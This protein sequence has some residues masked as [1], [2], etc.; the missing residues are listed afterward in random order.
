VRVFG[1]VNYR[2]RLPRLWR[3]PLGLAVAATAFLAPSALQASSRWETLEAIHRV[4]NPR[5]VTAPGRHGE[6]GA[7]QFRAST[8]R[9]HTSLPFAQAL[10]RAASE[11][12]AVRHYEWLRRGL[13]RNGLADNPYNIALA[14]NGGLSAAVQGRASSSAHEY[15]ERVNN[16]VA[17]LRANRL[18]SNP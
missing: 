12:V 11:R 9:M 16:I 7:Y 17:H 14:W 2:F 5:D 3:L 4:E 8:W 10:D 13:V 6:L 18:A 1:R 15:A